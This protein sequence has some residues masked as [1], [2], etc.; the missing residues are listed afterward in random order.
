MRDGSGWTRQAATQ[1]MNRESI[2][3]IHNLSSQKREQLRK[4][5]RSRGIDLL[6]LPVL[7]RPADLAVIPASFAQQRMWFL[8]QL[9]AGNPAYNVPVTVRLIGRLD[10]DVLTRALNEVLRRHDVLR[11]TF[12]VA[13]GM[14]VQVIAPALELGTCRRSPRRSGCRR[15]TSWPSRKP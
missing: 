15:L 2:E 13:D 8:D 1:D 6:T 4:L 7:R 11:T 9:D 12:A 14:P 5:L 10:V 3:A